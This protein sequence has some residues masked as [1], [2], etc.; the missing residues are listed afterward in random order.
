MIE[1]RSRLYFLTLAVSKLFISYVR[2]IVL[3]K[4]VRFGLF[5]AKTTISK[6]L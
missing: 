5:Y 4:R 2:Q 1:A 3:S 6:H